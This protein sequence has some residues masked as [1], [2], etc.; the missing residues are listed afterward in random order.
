MGAAWMA[1][2]A[3]APAD[4][5]APPLGPGP[6]PLGDDDEVLEIVI[7]NSEIEPLSPCATRP[8]ER[9][10]DDWRANER[11]NNPWRRLAEWLSAVRPRR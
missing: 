1:V 2:S 5:Y 10:R 7:D 8:G 11:S 6:D 3:L 9:P 4:G